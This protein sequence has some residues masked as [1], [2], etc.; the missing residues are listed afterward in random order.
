MKHP[1][2][3]I[4]LNGELKMSP[5]KAAAQTAHAVAMFSANA[6]IDFLSH[7]KRTVIVLEAKD[8]M[9]IQ[10]LDMYLSDTD[11]E[12]D[13]YIDEGKNEVDAFSIT[14]L[15]AGPIE[16]DDEELR[17]IFEDLPLYNGHI[18]VGYIDRYGF[19]RD[20]V[21]IA[22]RSQTESGLVF[23]GLKRMSK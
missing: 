10:N 6:H 22:G 19:T 2:L 14:A 21:M 1:I 18:E 7:Y 11:I 15:A 12:A 4:V 16:Y 23:R 5:G 3:Y 17:S 8:A 20:S 13:Y 9:Q